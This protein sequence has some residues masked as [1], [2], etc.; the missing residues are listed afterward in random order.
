MDKKVFKAQALAIVMLILVIASIMGVSLF[1]RMAKDK[2]ASVNEQDS[3]I[4]LAEVDAML[5]FFV[6]VDVEQ[7]ESVLGTESYPFENMGEVVD[8]LKANDVVDEDAGSSSFAD[9]WCNGNSDSGNVQVVLSLADP[10][11]YIEVRPG[12]V[13]AYNLTDIST[14]ECDLR[15]NFQAVDDYA[16]FLVKKIIDDPVNGVSEEKAN[17][18]IQ[19][20][21]ETVCSGDIDAEDLGHE[22]APGLWSTNINWG[23]D[24]SDNNVHYLTFDLAE[25]NVVEIRVL[26]I[27]G[28]LKFNNEQPSCVQDRN[29]LPIKVSAEAT[30]NVT[31][32][33]EMFLPG[34]GMLGYS[35]LFDY[36]IYDSG[37]LQP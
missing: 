6:G 30:C 28:I 5:D 27:Y 19:R 20:G 14:T 1:S 32:G 3:A 31:R 8:F 13:A 29:F 24:G 36:G 25:S 22:E 26:P 37:Y 23:K 12:S 2:D 18:C 15:V 4:A 9:D 7:L 35:T 33:E 11:D 10:T 17:Y 21:I 16:V 34:S